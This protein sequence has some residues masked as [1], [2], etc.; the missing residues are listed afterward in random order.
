MRKLN[1]QQRTAVQHTKGP[2]LVIAGPGSGKTAVI[3]SRIQN[4]IESGNVPAGK[5]LVVTFSRKA[6]DEMKARFLSMQKGAGSPCFGTFHSIFF[7]ILREAYQLS[8]DNIITEQ[9]K[10][11]LLIKAIQSTLPKTKKSSDACAEGGHDNQ[12][13]IQQMIEDPEMLDRLEGE[14]SKVK[15]GDAYIENFISSVVSPQDFRKIYSSYTRSLKEERLVDF[16]D[17]ISLC[18]HLLTE[19]PDLLEYWQRRFSYILVDEFQDINP[20]QYQIVRMLALPDNNLFV[21]GDDDQSIYAFRGAN[22]KIM[23]RFVRDYPNAKQITL[24]VNYRCLPA[25]LEASQKVIQGNRDRFKKKLK[26]GRIEKSAG[27]FSIRKFRDQQSE[28]TWIAED[29]RSRIR[30]GARPSELAILMRTH[31]EMPHICSALKKAGIPTDGSSVQLLTMHAAKGLE[32]DH[33]YLPDTNE[34]MIPSNKTKTREALCEERRIFYVAMT[35][36]ADSLTICFCEKIRSKK[37]APSRFLD[38]FLR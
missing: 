30:G 33:V 23:R 34:G 32:F 16:D 2:A 31:R 7:W 20:V 35:R 12:I 8:S 11:S 37:A 22:P 13:L 28:Y 9:K 26:S 10:K 27:L 15:S 5:I 21:V 6:A 4:L 3:V 24:Q 17:M 18:L 29:I 25:I 38:C 14:I 19:R 1:A 36:A